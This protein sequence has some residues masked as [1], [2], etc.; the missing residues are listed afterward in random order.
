MRS[1]STFCSEGL[2][3][4]K[5]HW[6]HWPQ[7]AP[8]WE[9]IYNRCPDASFFL[10][11]QWVDC[12][13]ATFGEDLNPD[14][15]AFARDGEKVGCCLLVWRTEWVRGIPLRRVYLNCAG[16]NEA[17]STCIE[18]NSVLSRPDCAEQVAK[19]LGGFLRSRSWDELLLEGVMENSPICA[20]ASS[21]GSNEI[22]ERP[23]H[24]VDFSAVRSGAG[25]IDAVLSSNTRQQI[26]RSRRLYEQESGPCTFSVARTGSEATEIF[27]RLA[28]LH[29]TAWLDRG[30]PGVFASPRFAG[31]HQELIQSQFAQGRI[32]L[33]ETRAGTEVIGVVYCFLHRGKVYFYQSGFRYAADGR[34]KPGLFTHY[35]AIRH[36][37]EQPE[38]IEYDFLAGDSQYKRSLA[39]TSRPLRWMVVRRLTAP[40]LVF[41]GLRWARGFARGV[42]T[43]S[44]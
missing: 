36:C 38:L 22:S 9:C 21:L 3:V 12:W 15:L 18:Y 28:D 13:L 7:F 17:D 4:Q 20:V 35:L 23:S 1:S 37:L 29:Q 27:A 33:A 14:V 16:E 5:L 39:T 2:A 6:S 8:T 44:Q 11:R 30:R 32:M 34:L 40:T 24:Y 25:G 19:A 10:S 41:R 43:N 26:R 31:F 42:N